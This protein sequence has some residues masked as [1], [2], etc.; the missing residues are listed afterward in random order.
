MKKT[1]L[2]TIMLLGSSLIYGKECPEGEQLMSAT[3][4]PYEFITLGKD[5]YICESLAIKGIWESNT[6]DSMKEIK[7]EMA[8]SRNPLKLEAFKNLQKRCGVDPFKYQGL[9]LEKY[10]QLEK[11]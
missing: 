1:I 9:C 11:L 6:P 10:K 8:E 4:L 3:S 7:K 5:P 2:L